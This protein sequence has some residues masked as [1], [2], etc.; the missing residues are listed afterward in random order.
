MVVDNFIKNRGFV[1]ADFF[2]PFIGEDICVQAEIRKEDFRVISN[3]I[4]D[5]RKVK[6]FKDLLKN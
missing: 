6:E 4:H 5:Q 3:A 1:L 2:H